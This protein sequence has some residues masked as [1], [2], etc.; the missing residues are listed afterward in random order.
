MRVFLF[1]LFFAAAQQSN[2]NINWLVGWLINIVF[3]LFLGKD[4]FLGS[5]CEVVQTTAATKGYEQHQEAI[6]GFWFTPA[7]LPFPD[8]SGERDICVMDTLVSAC[9]RLRCG[10]EGSRLPQETSQMCR[11]WSRQG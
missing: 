2:S 10:Q 8:L 11:Q 3:E 4:D 7:S 5:Q 1:P 6:A 9:P